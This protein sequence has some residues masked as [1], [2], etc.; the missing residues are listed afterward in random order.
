MRG[1]LYYL[2]R[3]SRDELSEQ[4]AEG[5]EGGSD[6][7][8]LK[9]GIDDEADLAQVTA[10]REALGE[11]PRLRL[12]ANGAWTPRQ[13]LRFLERAAEYSL[14]LVEQ[15]VRVPLSRAVL[16]SNQ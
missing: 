6:V 14:D 8:Y 9:V 5:L 1:E 3:G 16:G 2:A 7:F 12:D 10:V 13:A 15:P 4:C 11:G